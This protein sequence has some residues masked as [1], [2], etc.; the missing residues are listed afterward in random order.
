MPAVLFATHNPI[1]PKMKLI[2]HEVALAHST[3]CSDILTCQNKQPVCMHRINNTPQP[4]SPGKLLCWIQVHTTRDDTLTNYNLIMYSIPFRAMLDE[5]LDGNRLCLSLTLGKHH[6]LVPSLDT[7]VHHTS[8]PVPYSLLRRSPTSICNI[9]IANWFYG[10]VFNWAH[11]VLFIWALYYLWWR[12][13]DPG[14]PW[15]LQP[16][17]TICNLH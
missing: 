9:S 5:D 8:S 16:P 2:I 3:R 13:P 10:H 14:S 12:I 4:L 1:P 7:I 17:E 6:A 11:H 15:P